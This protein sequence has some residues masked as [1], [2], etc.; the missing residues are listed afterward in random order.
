MAHT[1][2]YVVLIP[3]REPTFA[4]RRGD[5][6]AD[7]YVTRYTVRAV[8]HDDAVSKALAEF[9]HNSAHSGVAW[10]REIAPDGIRVERL[11]S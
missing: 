4:L 1:H 9:S 11:E 5:V 3:Y 8:D 2:T 10:V 6:P 7:L